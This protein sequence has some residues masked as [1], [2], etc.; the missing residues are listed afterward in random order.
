MTPYVRLFWVSLL[1][2]LP[3]FAQT[4][5]QITGR[6]TDPAGAVIAGASI[7]IESVERGTRQHSVANESGYYLFTNLDPGKYQVS[8]KAEGFRPMT[9]SDIQLDVN[10]SARIDFKLEI[11]ALAQSVEV[12]GEN[13][14]LETTSA[15]LGTVVSQ[16]KISNLP[17]NAR[18]FTQLLTLTP[19]AAPVDTAQTSNGGFTQ[20]VGI[21]V[22]PAVNGQSNRSNTFL[23]DGV[24]NTGNYQGTYVVAPS[25]DMLDEFKVQS[26]GDE[27]R[28]GGVT[29]GIVNIASKSGTNQYH[30]TAYEFM[31]NDFFDARDFFAARKPELRQN[32]FGGTVG[33]PVIHNRLFFF[34]SYEGYRRVDQANV[35]SIT[36][37]QAELNGDFSAISKRIYDPLTTRTDPNNPQLYVRDLF[38]GNIIPSSR[39]SPSIKAWTASVLPPPMYT[40]VTGYNLRDSDRETY[41]ANNYSIRADHYITPNSSAW[42]RYTWGL[43]D[44]NVAATFTNA[45]TVSHIPASNLG[46]GYTHTFG[47]S[48]VLSAYFGYTS[49]YDYYYPVFSQTD[50]YAKGFFKGIPEKLNANAPGIAVPG[51]F[52]TSVSV[53]HTGP[54]RGFQWHADLSHTKGQH[55]LVFGGEV[56]VL[57]WGSDTLNENFTFNATQTADLNNLGTTGD[58]AASFVLGDFQQLEYSGSSYRVKT[59]VYALYAQ[60]S[61]KVNDKLTLNYGLRWDFLQTPGYTN[62]QFPSDWDFNTGQF[63]VGR[64]RPPDCASSPTPPCLSDPNNPYISQHV[65][66]TGSTKIRPN[67][68][69]NPGPRFGFAYRLQPTTVVRGS[70]GILYDL[71]AGVSQQAQNASANNANWPG[72]FGTTVITNAKMITQ[73]ADDPF[74]GVSPS[75]P[76]ATPAQ[77]TA[78]YYDPRFKNPYSEQ[79]NFEIQKELV[80]NLTITAGYVGSHNLDLPVGGNYNTALYPA[81]GAI[82][83]RQLYSYAPVTNYDRSVGR[84][85]Y[86]ALQV[87]VERRSAKGLSYLFAYTWSKS[88]DIASSGQ[89]GVENESLQ[90]PYD[91][92]SSKSVSGFDIPQVF[93]G[94]VVYELPFGH[95]KQWLNSGPLAR[96][97]SN[98]QVNSILTLR[99]GQPFTL[100]MNTDIANIGANTQVSE[101]RPNLVGDPHLSNPAP[102]AWFNTKAFAAP[103][104]FTFGSAGRNILRTAGLDDLDLSLFREDSLTE[105]IKLQ[106]RAEVFNSLNHPTFGTPQAVFTNSQFGQITTTVSTARQIQL[107]L[108]ILF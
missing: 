8:V 7:E 102:Q 86:D 29:G 69:T 103:K 94:A 3:C 18:N 93:S 36:P 96:I 45:F 64:T 67:R 98:W 14:L 44:T 25:I 70:F 28:F 87:K 23:L 56:L 27:A 89:F 21:R 39:L 66:F 105:K 43:Q 61:W 84:S 53:K 1:A 22:Y 76:A 104:A 47:P 24:Y 55:S 54:Q 34:F 40:G 58:A 92:N 101:D 90:N 52:S 74:N 73:T 59:G 106:L 35:L 51:Y 19:G 71:M 26:H 31:R 32:Q 79:W 63:I 10:Q 82:A 91:P 60:D 13:P 5:A 81:A 41:P 4:A 72:A 46:G 17:L 20:S 30:G 15:Q 97:V 37:T 85:T 65:V 80:R 49:T 9:H 77:S 99:S 33:G 48:T 95:G 57:P 62:N 68:F 38:P 16:D 50:L 11:G 6:V 42:F 108:K 2:A 12:S 107:G 83:P 100:Y 75:F 78:Y 88:I